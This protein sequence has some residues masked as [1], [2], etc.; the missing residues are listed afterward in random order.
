[1]R[2]LFV[3]PLKT[4]S[5]LRWAAL[6]A[7]LLVPA[8]AAAQPAPSAKPAAG[9]AK[10][11][12][13]ASAIPAASGAPAAPTASQ[14]PT[15]AA[16]AAPVSTPAASTAAPASTPAPAASPAPTTSG[17]ASST[18]PDR[19]PTAA[20]KQEAR[21]HFEKGLTLMGEE[22]W[23]AALAEFLLSLDLYAT[24]NALIN[25]GACYQKLQRFDDA[26]DAYERLM[27]TY[28]NLPADDKALAQKAI[29]ELRARVGT[30]DVVGGEPGA[31]IVVSGQTRGELPLV[32]PLR[33]GAG[34]HVIRVFKEGFEPFETRVDLAGGQTAR[35]DVKL[36]PLAA[37]GRLKVSE[38][39][40]R[41]VEVV[42]DNIAM[43]NAPWDGLVSVGSHVV[44]LREPGGRGR[45]GTQPVSAAVKTGEVTTLSLRAEDLDSALRIEPRPPGAR[46]FI[47]GVDVGGG[48]WVGRLRSGKHKVEAYE[49]G[50][51][52]ET[53]E[54]TLVSGGRELVN[55]DLKRDDDAPRWKKPSKWV[56]EG[57]LGLAL[58][59][60]FGGDVGASCDAGCQSGVAIGPSLMVHGAYELGSGFGL[61]VSVGYVLAFHELRQR[62]AGL[63]LQPETNDSIPVEGVAD[64]SL[65]F[66]SALLGLH[67]SYRI[68]ETFP[69]V[70]RASG[71]I[72]P[73]QIR[74]D[75]RGLFPTLDGTSN[76]TLDPAAASVNTMMAFV[77]PEARVGWRFSEHLE[78]TFGLRALILIAPEAPQWNEPQFLNAG[79]NYGQGRYTDE[80]LMG[81]VSVMVMPMLGLRYD[82]Q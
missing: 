39:G 18:D 81:Q 67:L 28:P 36:V 75:R 40:G 53:R 15:A 68:G 20:E 43:G 73:G 72:A 34:S 64:E 27:R 30:F 58:G 11:A 13:S 56:V 71:G 10:P 57:S 29:T 47:N 12:T 66:Q 8:F 25:A 74:S 70:L 45:I 48:Q 14:A 16:T 4:S 26:L 65:R 80:S 42:V 22:A 1:M 19:V 55:F 38:V 51:E 49:E 82:V 69:F 37:S 21:S 7:L 62:K 50:F 24:R 78:A 61:G 31:T 23:A 77:A 33:A 46:V 79:A 41:A 59:A 32:A 63:L 52:R 17:S 5:R 60:G 35:I 3:D 2:R 6:G 54:V 76:V 9:P 44:L